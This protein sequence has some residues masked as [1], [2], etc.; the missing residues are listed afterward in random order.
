MKN[1]RGW[2]V[3]KKNEIGAVVMWSV[4]TPSTPT[5]LVLI[6]VKSAVWNLGTYL[7][8]TKINVN[9]NPH[10]L[11]KFHGMDGLQF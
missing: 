6:Q 7:K 11:G 5:M 3:F 1:R 8:R 9:V 10:R 4:C 2:P